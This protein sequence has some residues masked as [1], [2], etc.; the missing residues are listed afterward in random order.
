MSGRALAA[1]FIG[2][3]AILAA[4][5]IFRSGVD[6]GRWLH[7]KANAEKADAHPSD[8]AAGQ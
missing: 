5:S 1:V 7:G 2:A 3:I 8:E 6:F 4:V